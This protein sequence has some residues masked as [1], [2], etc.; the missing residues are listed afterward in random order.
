MNNQFEIKIPSV[1]L[2]EQPDSSSPVSDELLYGTLVTCPDRRDGR[3]GYLSVT[4]SY[5]YTGYCARTQLSP[6]GND[7]IS[8]KPYFVR[9]P[10]CD[11]L[12]APE[13]RY[14]PIMTI[15][16]GSIVRLFT[17]LDERSRFVEGIH[18]PNR[19]YMRTDSLAEF[20]DPTQYDE[21]DLRQT[22]LQCALSYLGTPYRWGGKSMTGIDCSGLC[23]MAYFMAGLSLFRDAR[24]DPRYVREI[25]FDALLPADLVYFPGH[26]V[27]YLGEGEYV[28]ASA[29]YGKV[30]ISSF[31]RN[32]ASYFS[33]LDASNGVAA[34]S[35]AFHPCG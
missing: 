34:R 8:G 27:L 19:C 23:F 17:P 22:I 11:L 21:P 18:G 7:P 20:P 14:R 3:N 9:A 31:N 10:F 32:S 4:T 24:P 5:G 6:T 33:T 12:P 25:P 16:K 29:T 15:T 1:Y 13:Y 35:T 26:V 30:V 2:F 28:H